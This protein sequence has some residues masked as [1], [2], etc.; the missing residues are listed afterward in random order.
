ML[1]SLLPYLAFGAEF[2][3]KLILVG[4]VLLRGRGGRSTA[5][6]AW[7]VLIL[8]VPIVG[9]LAYLLIGEVRLGRRRIA[10]HRSIVSQVQASIPAKTADPQARNADVP[11]AFR[12]I[13]RLGEAVGP[14]KLSIFRP[15]ERPSGV[16]EFQWSVRRYGGS[17][18]PELIVSMTGWSASAIRLSAMDTDTRRALRA[19]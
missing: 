13:A 9:L 6:L 8:A 16:R 10:R 14:Q 3:L 17:S 18:K 12:P 2:I 1:P 5:A 19:K 7:I 15:E 4:V 11:A